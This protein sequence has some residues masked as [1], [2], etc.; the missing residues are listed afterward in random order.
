MWSAILACLACAPA[1]LAQARFPERIGEREFILDEAGLLA[2]DDRAAIVAVCDRLLTD[3]RI[4]IIVVTIPSLASYDAHG[5]TIERYAHNLFDEW[6]I[7]FPDY[8]YGVLLL[9]ATGDRKA[10]IQLGADWSREHDAVCQEIMDGLIIP[11]FKQ[12]EFSAG[13]R[14][15]V[16]A[17][18]KM[19]R[20]EAIPRRSLVERAGGT[21][22]TVF[23]WIAR[24]LM[25]LLIVPFILL[26]SILGWG[27]RGSSGGGGGWGGGSFG[28]GFS[29]GG[30]A[31]GSW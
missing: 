6:G 28:G 22:S 5:W 13:S 17:L 16:E 18:D 26:R 11:R 7:G 29:G 31:S 10:R 15:G 2:P 19:A 4:P 24:N 21:V 3:R 12:G 30:G 14:A 8:N 25:L 20:G 27:N 1:A 9:V 23:S